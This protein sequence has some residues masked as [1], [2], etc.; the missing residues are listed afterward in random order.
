MQLQLSDLPWLELHADSKNKPHLGSNRATWA[1]SAGESIGTGINDSKFMDS[2]LTELMH[3][4][5]LWL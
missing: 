5:E 4:V 1:Q 2:L 3:V